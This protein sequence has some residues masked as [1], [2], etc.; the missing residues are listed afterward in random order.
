ML[1]ERNDINLDLPD[2][3]WGRTLLAWATVNGHGNIAEMI[4]ERQSVRDVT[5]GTRNRAIVGPL[6]RT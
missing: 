6:R 4:L 5:S 2:I 1:L 3:Q